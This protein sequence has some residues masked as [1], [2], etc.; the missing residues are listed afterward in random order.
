MH[1]RYKI[2]V[3]LFLSLLIFLAFTHPLNPTAGG[4]TQQ[5]MPDLGGATIR[6]ITFIDSLT[7]YAVTNLRSS[8]D[9]AYIL[10]TTNGGDNWSIK[11]MHDKA[12]VR[13]LFINANIGFTNAFTKIFKTTNGGDNWSVINLPSI[14]GDD[15]FVLNEDIIWLAM[16][17][18]LT[19]GVHLT[20][21]GGLNWDRQFS[22][23][24]QNPN[25]IYMYNAR[26]GF[27]SN[28]SAS[29]NIY[30]TTNG[31]ENWT[32]NVSGERFFDISFVDSLIGWRSSVVGNTIYKT[33]NGGTNWFTQIIPNGGIIITAIGKFSVLNRDT[34]WGVGGLVSFGS[35]G[36][37]GILYRTTNGGNNWLFQLPDT[38]IH[39]TGY[40]FVQF[41]N[42]NTGWAYHSS[43]GGIHTVTGGDT[44]WLTEVQKISTEIPIQFKL[45]QNYP[46]P[47]NPRTIIKYE[48]QIT[49]YVKLAVYDIQGKEIMTLVN[50]KQNLGKYQVDFSGNGLS[51]GVYFYSLLV[52]NR[53]IDTK[54]MI[55]LK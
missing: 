21:N 34:V 38:S 53:L 36:S 13:V 42:R 26:I 17:E 45:Y 22:G 4:W 30:K 1:K 39:I 54:K 14:F 25:K 46:N 48:L 55:L 43:Q 40:T 52:D 31:G 23:G 18:S 32:V 24:N 3:S 20:T 9:S 11:F 16:S 28:S 2:L 7:G 35:N 50:Q 44:N 8:N 12:F 51:S 47:F 33:T 5:F 41:I 15:I 27:I 10:K 37:R 19:G 49:S 29:P 6:D